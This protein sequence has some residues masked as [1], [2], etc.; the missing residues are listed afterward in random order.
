MAQQPAAVERSNKQAG[1]RPSQWR[2][3]PAAV[4]RSNK[5]ATDHLNGAAASSCRAQQQASNRPSQW[6]SSQLL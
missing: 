4:E 1:N 2:S 6:R 3:Q 5:Q